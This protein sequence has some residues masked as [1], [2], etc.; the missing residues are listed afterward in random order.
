VPAASR[1]RSKFIA[2]GLL[3]LALCAALLVFLLISDGSASSTKVE[4]AAALSQEPKPQESAR[5]IKPDP[6]QAKADRGPIV[7]DGC[8]VGKKGTESD[9]CVYGDHH[10]KRTLVLFGDSHAMQ[11]FPP[12]KKLAEQHRWRLIVLNKRECTPAEAQVVLADGSGEYH[13]C[14]LWHQNSLRRIEQMGAH[15]TV[16]L[17]GD[18][19]ALAFVHGHA[20]AEGAANAAVLQHGYEATLKRILRS[21]AGAI[22]IQDMP[23]AP[24]DIPNCVERNLEHLREC[25]FP[26]LPDAALEFDAAAARAVAGA[27]LL[28]LVPEVC[29]QALCRAVIGNALVYRD[30]HHLSATFARTLSP[31]IAAGLK[32]AGVG[33][34][35]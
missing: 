11:Y 32:A 33:T 25:A 23:S 1:N 17:S 27:H 30:K 26:H 21:G 10:G 13:Q 22:V 31:W 15:T 28:D 5:V 24:H 12:L 34:T 6:E 19:A 3:G 18:K 7:A 4:G 29:P 35:H 16:I 14:D 8:M 2:W 20:L 9:T